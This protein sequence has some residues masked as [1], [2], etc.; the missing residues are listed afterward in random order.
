M[1]RRY[2]PI[3]WSAPLRSGCCGTAVGMMI[4][5]QGLRGGSVEPVWGFTILALFFLVFAGLGAMFV[6]LGRSGLVARPPAGKGIVPEPPPNPLARIDVEVEPEPEDYV[7]TTT[8]VGSLQ[9]AVGSDDDGED[10]DE[11][12]D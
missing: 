10:E 8:E 7:E 1:A 2:R 4:L 3:G 5:L 12:E 9:S 11:D 6:W